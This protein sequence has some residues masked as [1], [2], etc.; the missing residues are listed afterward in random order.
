MVRV[1]NDGD[2]NAGEALRVDAEVVDAGET[3][4]EPVG[5]N[6][7]A[8]LDALGSELRAVYGTA[9]EAEDESTNGDGTVGEFDGGVLVERLNDAMLA[10][11]TRGEETALASRDVETVQLIRCKFQMKKTINFGEELRLTGSHSK[12]GTWNMSKSLTLNWGEGDV[13]TSDDIELPVDGVF[14]YKYAI[15]PAG[16]PETVLSWQQGNNNVLMLSSDDMP[17]LWINDCWSGNPDKASLFREGGQSESKEDR[18]ISRVKGADDAARAA[19]EQVKHL[20]EDLEA[21][22]LQVKAL[23]QEARLA[24]NVRLALK[25]Q[26]RVE[27]QRSN[28]LSSQIDA[29]KNKFLSLGDGGRAS[30]GEEEDDDEEERGDQASGS[31]ANETSNQP[32]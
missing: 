6:A 15:V 5:L 28:V 22:S 25:E 16:Q 31:T 30:I 18:L 27:K 21:A 12:L 3:R 20:K 24:A 4:G 1:E 7:S 2:G 17:R 14:I 8:R 23:R 13:W 26:L 11:V 19:E 10:R 9:M 29:W 32:R